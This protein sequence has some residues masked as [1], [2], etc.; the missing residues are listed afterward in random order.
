MAVRDLA[1]SRG[2]STLIFDPLLIQ[3]NPS[4]NTRDMSSESTYKKEKPLI[5][6]WSNKAL[7]YDGNPK[8]GRIVHGS[9]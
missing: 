5:E 6:W 4:D 7:N 2:A 1:L 3:E 8:E 9:D